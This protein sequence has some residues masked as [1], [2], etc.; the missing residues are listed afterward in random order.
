[1]TASPTTTAVPAPPESRWWPLVRSVGSAAVALAALV[2]F[3]A[4]MGGAFREKVHPGEAPVPRAS[5]AGRPTATVERRRVADT[6]PVVGSVQPRQRTE[7]SAQLLARIQDV[8][9]RPGD[10]VAPGQ[11]LVL[12]DDRE[13]RT[14]LAEA[15]AAVT[16]AQADLLL[17]KTDYG[18]VASERE[19][20]VGSEADFARYEGAYRVAEAQVKRSKE[21][22]ARLAVQLTYTR[23]AATAR[24]VVGDRFADPGDVAAPGKVLM[25]LYDPAE[26]E[27]HVNVPEGLAPDVREG[28]Q[29]RVRIEAAGLKDVVGAVREVV[30]QAQQASRAVLVKVALPRVPSAKP[31]LPG[32]FGRVAVPVGTVE[33]LFVPRAAVRQVGQLDLVE[34]VDPDGTLSRRFVRIG[35]ADGDRVEV[36][37]GLDAGET[38]ALPDR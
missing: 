9:V 27:L 18:R 20:G 19:K 23:I 1:M 31:L 12:L 3:L 36:L 21:Y 5:A 8:K 30:P 11:E 15:Q 32:M 35:S 34:V 2:A 16:V 14:Q 37:S 33:R 26:L 28:L 17:R 22:V 7:V 24:G 6:A 25:V 4:W 13:L 29:L 38:V 10:A